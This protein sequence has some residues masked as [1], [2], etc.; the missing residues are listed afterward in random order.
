[1]AYYCYYILFT[2]YATF[3]EYSLPILRCFF[4]YI[5]F[6]LLLGKL[7]IRLFGLQGAQIG[8][9]V[10]KS[11]TIDKN[12]EKE[13]QPRRESFTKQPTNCYLKRPKNISKTRKMHF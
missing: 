8:K 4:A 2:T 9:N 6:L 5:Y 12:T 13:E 11:Q 1:M 3:E 7:Y 10:S